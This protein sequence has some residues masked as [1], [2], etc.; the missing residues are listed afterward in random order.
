LKNNAEIR[1]AMA[2]CVILLFAGLTISPALAASSP[3]NLPVFAPVDLIINDDDSGDPTDKEVNVPSYNPGSGITPILTINFTILGTNSS[4]TTA[5]YGDDPGED[6]KN[7][8]ISGDILYPVN[9]MTLYHVGTNGDWNCEVTPTKPSGA[10]TLTIDWPG[11]GTA[12]ET[13]QIV[14]GTV[15]NPWMDSFQWG[16]DCNIT[17]TITNMDG[18]P[19]KYA[20]VCLIWEEDDYEFNETEGNNKV[21]NG[22]NGEYR[23]WIRQQDQGDLPPKNIT[24]AAQM[25]PGSSFWG[26][27]KV[28]MERPN[29]P[30]LVFVDDDYNNSTPGWGYNHFNTI[31]DGIN[32]VQTNGT[33]QVSNGTYSENILINKSLS[34]LGQNK[35]TTRIHGTGNGTGINITANNVTI[36]GFTIRNYTT[37]YG[38][39]IAS[40]MN[41]ITNN[42]IS[43]TIGGIVIYWNPFAPT[44]PNNG[45]NII[46]E[47]MLIDNEGVGIIVSGKN[48]TIRNNCISQSEYGIMVDLAAS[49]N[50]SRNNIS[51]NDNGIFI[52]GSY[53]TMIYQNTISKNKEIGVFDFCTSSTIIRRNNFIGNGHHAYFHQAVLLRIRFFKTYFD[54]P[55]TRSTWQENYWEKPR[56]LPYLIPGLISLAR[57]FVTDPLYQVN[58]FQIDR[59][60]AKN[61]YDINGAI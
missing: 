49:N 40:R 43:D 54:F 30:P 38:I 29:N 36:N 35:N 55:I 8:T 18:A 17:V 31:Q 27:A 6:W 4:E 25:Y 12:T 7:I 44:Y 57:G 51:D 32:A 23:F 22:L 61:P 3:R 9:D 2:S 5:F 19:E 34:L 14:N 58:F 15:V 52:L 56:M 53:S 10:I 48:N 59:H 11:N 46:T 21:G 47:N 50:I 37:G 24:F 42:I 1:K 20:K 39:I 60:P 33:V 26:Y 13:I 16:A 28:M 45:Y 41:R